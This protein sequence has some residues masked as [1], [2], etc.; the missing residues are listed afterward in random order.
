ML[1][2]G[3]ASVRGERLLA[4]PTC[5]C[6]R[7]SAAEISVDGLRAHH[8]EGARRTL[9]RRLDLLLA[10]KEGCAG[11]IGAS[12]GLP[13][14][15]LRVRVPGAGSETGKN[16][17]QYQKRLHGYVSLSTQNKTYVSNADI[18]H[19]PRVPSRFIL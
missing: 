2:P 5:V 7:I 16:Q 9:R 15:I 10:L 3:D 14:Y 18:G 19:Q 8:L 11:E 4:E 6:S 17:R 13:R 12:V 1:L